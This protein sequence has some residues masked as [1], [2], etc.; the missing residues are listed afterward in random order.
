MRAEVAKQESSM[1]NNAIYGLSSFRG[2]DSEFSNCVTGYENAAACKQ[3]L[4]RVILVVVQ[5]L[6]TTG[7]ICLLLFPF[8]E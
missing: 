3:D 7:S 5:I 1:A 4:H 8:E 6:Q 2:E